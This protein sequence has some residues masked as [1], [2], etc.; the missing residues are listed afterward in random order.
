M[1]EITAEQNKL[2]LG[3]LAMWLVIGLVLTFI[4]LGLAQ[5][6]SA[7]PDDG[8][9]PDFTLRTYAGDEVR[10]SD[11]GGQVVVLNFWA[12]WCLPCRDEAPVL[13]QAWRDYQPRGV[14]FVGVGYQDT[15]RR[16]LAYLDE[17]G[18]SYPNGPDLRSQISD[19]YNIRGVPET[20][21]IDRQGN[22]VFFVAA[23]ITEEQLVT[24]IEAALAQE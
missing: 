7:Q 10:L 12:S 17:F 13:E 23:P 11:L 19:D 4:G 18:I 21:I 5:A 3:Q 24:E 9:A 14:M 16:A 2:R 22:V 6:L 20:F 8:R 1:T 15:D